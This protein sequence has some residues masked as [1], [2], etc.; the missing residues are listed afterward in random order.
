VLA[1]LRKRLRSIAAMTHK[2]VSL[3][4]PWRLNRLI[5]CSA[6]HYLI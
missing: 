2:A 1:Y 4:Q 6:L 5:F 3:L